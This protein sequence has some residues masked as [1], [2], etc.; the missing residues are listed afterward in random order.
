M[1]GKTKLLIRDAFF[2]TLLSS[3]LI[4]ILAIVIFNLRFFNPFHKAFTDFSFLDVYYAEKFHDQSKVNTDIVLV[5]VGKNRL[6]IVQLLEHIIQQNPKAIGIDVIFKEEKDQ[7]LDSTLATLLNHDKIITSFEIQE[8]NLVY[9]NQI[10]DNNQSSGFVNFNFDDKTSVIRK[11]E[12]KT[13]VNDEESLS[14]AAEVAKLSLGEKWKEYGF[15]TKLNKPQT[16]KYHGYYDAFHYLDIGD[17]NNYEKKI[18]LKDKI[19]LLGYLGTPTGNV[20]DIEDKYFTPLNPIFTGKSVPDMYGVTV[21]ANILNMM[22]KNDF[23]YSPSTTTML[24]ITFLA[25]YLSTIF[26]M[27]INR[28]YK[29]SFRTRKRIFQF[30][31]SI[32]ILVLTFWLYNRNIEIK[33]SFLLVGIILA[34][35]YF[36]YY[37]HLTRYLKNKTQKKWKTYLK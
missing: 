19:V 30:V 32:F 28:N 22:V 29:V 2:S 31:I 18:T 17:F 15:D 26:Y 21:H 11:F 9:N 6:E 37:K 33:P 14:F 13:I 12:A 35:S 34:G 24:I 25:M 1:K 5:N 20:H 16:I 3:V 7:F 27:K 4:F 36:K 10:F 23:M 8:D